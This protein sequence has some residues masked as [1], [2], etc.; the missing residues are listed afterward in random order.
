MPFW[1]T[2]MK[3]MNPIIDWY[4]SINYCQN[5]NWELNSI[6]D[7]IDAT[8]KAGDQNQYTQVGRE[9]EK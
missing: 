7:I 8:T 2:E 5:D 3:F 9:N 6:P 4:L 1:I